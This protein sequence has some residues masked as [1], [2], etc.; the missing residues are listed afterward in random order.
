MAS[1]L[2]VLSGREVVHVFESFG[3]EFHVKVLVTLSW[4][5]KAKQ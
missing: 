4:L 2:P 1:T 5:R 3:W